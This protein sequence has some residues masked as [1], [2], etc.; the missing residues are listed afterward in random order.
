MH[1]SSGSIS[2]CSDI[3]T[4]IPITFIF[5]VSFHVLCQFYSEKVGTPLPLL[6][7]SQLHLESHLYSW[8]GTTSYHLG[9]KNWIYFSLT[10][11]VHYTDLLVESLS[12][13]EWGLISIFS[14]L[15]SV[16]HV[17]TGSLDHTE[18]IPS[19]P[20]PH[21]ERSKWQLWNASQNTKWEGLKWLRWTSLRC[22]ALGN[23]V[24]C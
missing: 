9:T 10:D 5:H 13:W 23:I 11:L 16:K 1:C 6:V 12:H 19:G 8:S 3:E 2:A 22:S 17:Q 24:K 21:C 14:L 15:L 18:P 7:D 4:F 20:L